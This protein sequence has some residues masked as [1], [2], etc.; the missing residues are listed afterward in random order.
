MICM[1]IRPPSAWTASATL[2]QPATCSALWMPGVRQY[3]LPTSLGWAPS[4]T[5]SPALAR[6]R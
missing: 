4:V 5:I 1:T 6:W 3:P 2:R